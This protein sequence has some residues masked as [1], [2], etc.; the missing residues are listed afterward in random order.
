MNEKLKKLPF[1]KK[2]NQQQSQEKD[3]A[4]TSKVDVPQFQPGFPEKTEDLSGKTDANVDEKKPQKSTPHRKP[5]PGKKKPAPKAKKQPEPEAPH[6]PY[7]FID[8]D[9]CKLLAAFIPFTVL[10][11]WLKDDIYKLTEKEKEQLA[12]MWDKVA[13]KYIPEVISAYSDE[14]ILGTTISLILIEKSGIVGKLINAEKNEKEKGN[15]H[16]KSS[17]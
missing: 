2:K 13:A 4:S 17:I 11:I 9:T 12:P 3:P 14:A 6:V 1:Q 15:D 8:K 16:E 5:S 10:A 7:Q